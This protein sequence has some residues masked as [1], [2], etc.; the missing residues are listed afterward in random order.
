MIMHTERSKDLIDIGT[1][2]YQM[3]F[4][5]DDIPDKVRQAAVH[6]MAPEAVDHV[7]QLDSRRTLRKETTSGTA[8]DGLRGRARAQAGGKERSGHLRG[9]PA[10]YR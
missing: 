7:F 1:R 6:A 8:R 10:P 4:D 9:G 2:D 5:K 3:K